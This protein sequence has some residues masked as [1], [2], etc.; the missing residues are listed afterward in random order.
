MHAIIRVIP[1]HAVIYLFLTVHETEKKSQTGIFKSLF[2]TVHE[3]ELQKFATLNV[4]DFF[5]LFR[6]MN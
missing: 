2:L 6:F 3:P 4:S 1:V 5:F